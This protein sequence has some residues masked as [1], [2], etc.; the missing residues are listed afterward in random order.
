MR[1]VQFSQG[2]DI[3]PGVL[4][5]DDHVINL[6][7][8]AIAYP[9]KLLSPVE[10]IISLLRQGNRTM[11][12]VRTLVDYLSGEI[13]ARSESLPQGVVLKR[14][15][16]R[17][18]APILDPQKII[19]V[20]LNYRD[21]CIENNLEPPKS[22]IIFAKYPSAII[23][24]EEAIVLDEEVARQIDYEAEF[25]FV[26]GKR[27]Q[28][29]SEQDAMDYVAGY[30]IVNDVSARDL[31]FAEGQWVRAKSLDTFCPLG[32]ALVTK[33]EVPDP[34]NLDVRCILNGRVV[35]YSNTKHLI[36]GVPYLVSFLSRGITLLPGDIISTGTPGGVGYHRKPQLFLKT[37]DTVRVEIEHIG[38]LSN[39]VRQEVHTGISQ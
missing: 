17:L 14:N 36:F 35:Q 37:G 29:V 18:A 15:D 20:G 31:Q 34:H 28:R 10:S 9:D 25:A 16:V 23:G 12:E 39:T 6:K 32:P 2:T 8:A 3:Y 26:M 27:A 19:A 1:F 11:K 13:I 22:P 5:G 30:T 7:A 38:I 21:H 4:A 24:D 33:D